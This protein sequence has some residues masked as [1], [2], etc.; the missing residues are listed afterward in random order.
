M[1]SRNRASVSGY[2][3][4][5]SEMVFAGAVVWVAALGIVINGILAFLFFPQRHEPESKAAY[6]HFFNDASVSAGVVI[7]G[8]LIYYTHLYWLDPV[9]SLGITFWILFSNR[10]LLLDSFKEIWCCVTSVIKSQLQNLR[11]A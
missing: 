4:F 3:L 6:V 8:I 10:R 5:K 11:D 9:I 1:A 2:G 7:T